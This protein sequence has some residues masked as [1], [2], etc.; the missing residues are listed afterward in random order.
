MSVFATATPSYAEVL[1]VRAGR[2]AM[3]RGFL[4]SVTP[5][6]LAQTR[7]N[8]HAPEYPETVLSCLHTILAEEWEHHRYAVLDLEVIEAGR[9]QPTGT[10][11]ITARSVRWLI[12]STAPSASADSEAWPDPGQRPYAHS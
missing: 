9:L 1:D 3:V 4:A 11:R 2:V 12:P 8:P 7:R 10:P 6:Q 5:Q